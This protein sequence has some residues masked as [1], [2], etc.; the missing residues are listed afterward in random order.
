MRD[1]EASVSRPERELRGFAKLELQPGERR[2]LRFALEPRA[3]S[4]WDPARAQWVAEP[5]EFEVLGGSSSRDIRART[6]F[7]LKA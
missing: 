1:V 2:T 4:F 7:A 3:L 6:A 5:G